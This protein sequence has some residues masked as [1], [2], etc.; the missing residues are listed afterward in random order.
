MNLLKITYL[1][2][3]I[4]EFTLLML[5]NNLLYINYRLLEA[6]DDCDVHDEDDSLQLF[7]SAA[8]DIPARK[9]TFKKQKYMQFDLDHFP[10]TYL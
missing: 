3:Q 10:F 9:P 2:M 7:T 8:M 6:L 1:S 4:D 5:Y